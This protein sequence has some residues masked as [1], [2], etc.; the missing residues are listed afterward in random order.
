MF[1]FSL[2][3]GYFICG[4]TTGLVLLFSFL[5]SLPDGKLHIIFCNVGQGDAAYIR[6]PDG[7]DM[8]VDG[9]P[10]ERVLD[11]LG[12]SMPFWDRSLDLVVLTH[13]QKD[14]LQGLLSVLARYQIGYLVRSNVSNTS[15]GYQQFVSRIK[16]HHI[17]ERF[18]TSGEL[19]TV[20]DVRLSVLWPTKAQIAD[21][22]SPAVIQ[23]TSVLGISDET[24]TGSLVF[25]LRF[26]S[27][28]ALFPGD[29]DVHVESRYADFTLADS[30]VELLKVPHHGSKYSMTKEYIDKLNPKISVISVGKN[31][32]GHPANETLTMLANKMS[33]VLR[34]DQDGDIEIISDGVSW[35]VR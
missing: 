24:N 13:P 17:H 23:G 5:S 12:K 31:T 3:V 15:E 14:H 6:L 19:I 30:T 33:R 4:L 27:F 11:C 29:A 2:R 34:T 32:Y 28:D 20:G 1:M 21:M 10:N 9:G 22:G 26:G 16:A 7:R 25:W 18:V 35:T 8:L